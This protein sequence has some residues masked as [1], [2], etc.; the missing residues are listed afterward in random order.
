MPH[1][2]KE[3][4]KNLEENSINMKLRFPRGLED[5]YQMLL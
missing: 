1:K 3:L 5:C 2:K 4:R